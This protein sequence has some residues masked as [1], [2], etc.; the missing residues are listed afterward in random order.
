MPGKQERVEEVIGGTITFQL[1]PLL[2]FIAGRN[3]AREEYKIYSC[4]KNPCQ[5]K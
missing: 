2:C 1:K 4:N 3:Y 5:N